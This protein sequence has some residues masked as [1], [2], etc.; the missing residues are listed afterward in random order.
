MIKSTRIRT[1]VSF[2]PLFFSHFL[3]LYIRK[4]CFYIWSIA[5]RF[6][7][8]PSDLSPFS[9]SLLSFFIYLRPFFYPVT[10]STFS[11]FHLLPSL[12]KPSISFRSILFSFLLLDFFSH[13]LFFIYSSYKWILNSSVTLPMYTYC[14][15]CICNLRWIMR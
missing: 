13:L 8:L 14:L 6:F 2:F 4:I 11:S 5:I 9:Y 1:F 3:T 15:R 10:F 12:L 7:F